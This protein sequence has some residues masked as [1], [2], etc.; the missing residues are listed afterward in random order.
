MARTFSR[1]FSSSKDCVFRDAALPNASTSESD[2]MNGHADSN[3]GHGFD[4][5]TIFAFA[6]SYDFPPRARGRRVS[7]LAKM[8]AGVIL[9][10][11]LSARSRFGIWS[12]V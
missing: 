5:E 9:S 2:A 7:V 3:G 6:V 8:P 12:L 10:R 1:Y 11:V 4:S